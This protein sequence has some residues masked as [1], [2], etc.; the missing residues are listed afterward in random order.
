MDPEEARGKAIIA[1]SHEILNQFEEPVVIAKVEAIGARLAGIYA[2][3]DKEG[4]STAAVADRLAE[5]KIAAARKKNAATTKA[6]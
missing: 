6:A 1:V 4:L 3:A 5:E 2:Q